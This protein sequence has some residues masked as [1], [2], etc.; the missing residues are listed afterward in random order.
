MTG[1]RWSGAVNPRDLTGKRQREILA[2]KDKHEK[3]AAIGP[4]A[5]RAA[6][7]KEVYAEAFEEGAAW[8]FETMANA[9]IDVDAVLSLDDEDDGDQAAEH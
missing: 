9:G 6:I 7:R 5:I 1:H 8:A 3:A 4:A 2:A